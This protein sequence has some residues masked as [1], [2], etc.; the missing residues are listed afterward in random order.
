LTV[1]RSVPRPSV[2]D[3]GVVMDA[4]PARDAAADLEM[5]V[6]DARSRQKL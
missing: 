1:E 4:E 5:I 2:E 6:Q 3:R